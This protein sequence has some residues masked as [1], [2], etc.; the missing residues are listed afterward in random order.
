M[1][2]ITGAAGDDLFDGLGSADTCNGLPGND[3][4]Q[5]GVAACCAASAM[6]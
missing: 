4:L 3:T 2:V 6:P 1:A 5:G